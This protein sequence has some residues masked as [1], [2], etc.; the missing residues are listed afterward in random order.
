MFKNLLGNIPISVWVVIKFVV[1]LVLLFS[2]ASTV[3]LFSLNSLAQLGGSEFYVPHTLHS[4]AIMSLFVI[5]IHTK[6]K[7]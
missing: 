6:I 3:L 1:V 4:Y 5:F 7:N 2:F